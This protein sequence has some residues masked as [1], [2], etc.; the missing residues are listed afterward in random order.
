MYN[1][2]I[3]IFFLIIV[4]IIGIDTCKN[5]INN[6]YN[7]FND[8]IIN[9]P[10][11]FETAIE[12][13]ISQKNRWININGMFLR[14]C[15]IT[16]VNDA[17]GDFFD[18]YKLDNGS[19]MYTLEKENVTKAAE[20]VIKLDEYLNN[21][22]NGELL[23]VQLPFKIENDDVMPI[24][25]KEYGNENADDLIKILKG[26][27]I[28]IL[29]LRENI[30]EDQL[31]YK[32]IFY[33]TDHHWKPE[34]ALWAADIINKYIMDKYG[35]DYDE[36]LYD[37][38]N[39]NIIKYKD[40]FLG[41]LGKRTGNWYS[42]V[43]DFSLIIP[44]FETSFDFEAETSKGHV[45]KTGDFREVMIDD[46]NLVKNYFEINTY[47]AYIGG[48][49]PINIIHNKGLNNNKRTLLLRDSFSCAM[50]PYLSLASE[51]TVALDL[52]HYKEQSLEEYLANNKFDCVII[53]YN[54]SSISDKKQFTFFR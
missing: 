40:W 29:D 42:E 25:S 11:N 39:Y 6:S 21:I 46:S 5:T 15:G 30:K 19:V 18:V 28:D 1:K 32:N 10:S 33:K 44:K 13:N 50:L 52:R 47:A 2:L 36:K 34:T 12:E 23:Y 54:P 38:D 9:I 51:Y 24:G 22:N 31:E 3:T 8:E 17:G 35:Y 48:D 49:F 14:I 4:F 27:D 43:D 53:A 45:E 26:N 41:S 37:T 16:Y 20:N 7:I